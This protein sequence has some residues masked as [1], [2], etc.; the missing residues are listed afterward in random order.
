VR[1][2]KCIKEFLLGRWQRVRVDGQISEEVSVN[3]GVPQ[4]SVLQM[5]V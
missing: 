4:G 5:T 1:V 3:S 2:I